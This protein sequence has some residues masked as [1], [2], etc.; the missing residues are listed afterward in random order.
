MIK[1]DLKKK[2]GGRRKGQAPIWRVLE[3]LLCHKRLSK[4]VLSLCPLPPCLTAQAACLF[5][6]QGE[7]A[8]YQFVRSEEGLAL[9][10]QWTPQ[11]T[12]A[13]IR[14]AVMLFQDKGRNG[15]PT[16]LDRADPFLEY[17]SIVTFHF[18]PCHISLSLLS[19]CRCHCIWLEFLSPYLWL[20]L[21]IL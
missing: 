4:A 2:K 21:S 7:E 13:A 9:A 10:F 8:L 17:S 19:V 11:G 15:S 12:Q 20:S 18:P 3:S 14:S 6:L 1:F 5:W 16:S